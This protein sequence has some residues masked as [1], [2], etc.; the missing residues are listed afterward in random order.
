MESLTPDRDELAD[1][2]GGQKEPPGEKPGKKTVGGGAGGP[3]SGGQGHGGGENRRILI[4]L[5]VLVVVV[6]ASGGWSLWEQQQTIRSLT[7][8]LQQAQKWISET[9]LR[10]ARMEGDLAE[11][12]QELSK[13]G[14]Q[15]QKQLTYLDSEMRKLWAVAHQTN[16]PAIAENKKTLEALAKDLEK[17]REEAT[18]ARS[19][20]GE[21]LAAIE[22]QG[23]RQ[24]SLNSQ[25]E[26]AGKQRETLAAGLETLE[27]EQAESRAAL[28]KA[29]DR[30][31]QNQSLAMDELR[32]RLDRVERDLDSVTGGGE[33]ETLAALSARLDQLE[34]VVASVDSARS[35]LTR[36]YTSLADRVDRLARQVVEGNN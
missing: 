23:Q 9:S 10:N 17:T 14:S 11:A 2:Q 22:E 27:Q 31:E 3:G 13:T 28:Q 29:I 30:A 25:L 33:D 24:E 4:L 8:D 19:R 34:P 32:A 6:A 12:D 18:A 15:V 35:Q 36:R 7:L 21:A 16:R 5:L 1:R 26:Q 20:A